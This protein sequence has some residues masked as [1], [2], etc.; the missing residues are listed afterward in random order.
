MLTLMMYGPV[1]PHRNKVSLYD[2]DSGKLLGSIFMNSR[3]TRKEIRM[4]FELDETIIIRRE[5]FDDERTERL[6]G[7]DC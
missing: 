4:C 3:V 5:K 2:R 6:N 7:N 1:S